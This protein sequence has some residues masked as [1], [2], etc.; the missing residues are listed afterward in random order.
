MEKQQNLT[1]EQLDMVIGG[2]TN[3]ILA[4]LTAGAKPSDLGQEF[5][6]QQQIFDNQQKF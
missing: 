4:M 2:S 3:V 6:K 5:A 1:D